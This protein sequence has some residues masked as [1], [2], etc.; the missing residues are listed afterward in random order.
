MPSVRFTSCML[1]E[2]TGHRRRT[3]RLRSR[4]DDIKAHCGERVKLGIYD[5][6][7]FARR[8]FRSA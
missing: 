6:L 7:V 3:G 4:S 5:W 2:G 1:E 8:G